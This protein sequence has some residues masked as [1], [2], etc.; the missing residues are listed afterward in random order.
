[1]MTHEH[2][3]NR[4]GEKWVEKL[5]RFFRQMPRKKPDASEAD[6]SAWHQ[7]EDQYQKEQAEWLKQVEASR[8]KK[9]PGDGKDP[10]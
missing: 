10:E 2:E 9:R 8:K 7:S 4:P 5:I 6:Y 1:M 3:Q